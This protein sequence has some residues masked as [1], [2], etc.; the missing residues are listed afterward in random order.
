MDIKPS[1]EGIKRGSLHGRQLLCNIEGFCLTGSGQ[2]LYGSAA[3][4]PGG[5][6]SSGPV[7]GVFSALW[8]VT[9][10]VLPLDYG[11]YRFRGI[12]YLEGRQCSSLISRQHIKLFW[13][14][15]KANIQTACTEMTDEGNA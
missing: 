1:S 8:N 6:V 11:A 7:K 9:M 15:R 4:F 14:S 13:K 3:A 2:G 10:S 12:I 5:T